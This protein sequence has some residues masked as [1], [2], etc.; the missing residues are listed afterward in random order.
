MSLGAAI[1]GDNAEV[2]VH[3]KKKERDEGKLC[4]KPT[5]SV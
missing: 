4:A 2:K 1:H 5:L 3:V